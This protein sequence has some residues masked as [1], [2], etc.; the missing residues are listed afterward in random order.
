V[1][2]SVIDFTNAVNE[3]KVTAVAV[4]AQR[5][6]EALQTRLSVAART[7]PIQEFDVDGQAERALRALTKVQPRSL[8]PLQIVLVS[9]VGN[10]MVRV[11]DTDSGAAASPSWKETPEW[12]AAQGDPASQNSDSAI[13]PLRPGPGGI[14]V[15][16]LVQAVRPPGD[17]QGVGML[18][19]DVPLTD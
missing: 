9:N 19:A 14:P 6:I 16:R 8:T 5:G 10:E 1:R 17:E 13:W 18:V 2:Q 11:P 7:Q 15:L 4:A 3:E 12:K